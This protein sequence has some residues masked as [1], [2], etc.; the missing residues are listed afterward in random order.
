[1]R[2]AVAVLSALTIS[3]GTAT[4]LAGT[5]SAGNDTDPYTL[6]NGHAHGGV[7]P[8][9]DSHAAR[10]GGGGNKNLIYHGG[11][12]RH[13]V[14]DVQAIFV[15]PSWTNSTF[16]Q[17]KITGLDAL[18][19][20]LTSSN[21]YARTNGEYYDG[22]GSVNPGVHYLGHLVD[23]A[24]TFTGDPGTPALGAEVGKLIKNPTPGGYYPVYITGAR[25][26]APYCAWHD[27]TTANNVQ[28]QVGFFFNLDGD[29]GCNPNAPS[30]VGTEGLAA[31]A[32]V[33]GHEYSEMV[34]D[35]LLTA[36]W[37][38]QGNENA[39]KCAWTFGSQ[40]LPIGTNRF[41]KIQGNW[42]NAAASSGRGYGTGRSKVVGC[43]DGTNA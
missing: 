12:V 17:D 25:N 27:T 10:P 29:S 11:P 39:D 18:Y 22:S 40:L 4:M 30:S 33:S 21:N 19:G 24:T 20:G 23:S 37:D 2:R 41:W 7:V 34:T 26:G 28:I 36:W 3:L 15:G 5:A 31:L 43:V 16:A 35:P 8:A 38:Q 1:M 6:S 32:N 14:T 13:A 9:R 42:S